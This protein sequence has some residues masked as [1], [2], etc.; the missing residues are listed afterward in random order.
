[1]GMY[2]ELRMAVELKEHTPDEIINIL[3]YMVGNHKDDPKHSEYMEHD[4][5]K[6]DRWHFMLRCDSYYFDTETNSTLKFDRITN[7]YFLNIQCNFKNYENELNL[8]LD[9]IVPHIEPTHGKFIGHEMYEED[10]IPTLLFY[11]ERGS[12]L[13]IHKLHPQQTP[14]T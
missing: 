12:E 6:C 2:T 5:F 3:N 13:K 11:P 14:W 1:M 9:W 10:V 8:F 4:L 7:T